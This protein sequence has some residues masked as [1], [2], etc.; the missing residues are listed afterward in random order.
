MRKPEQ[1]EEQT[2]TYAPNAVRIPSRFA[3][4][5]PPTATERLAPTL[6]RLATGLVLVVI[7]AAAFL[8]IP[9]RDWDQ[10][11]DWQ[12]ARGAL[13]RLETQPDSPADMKSLH[14]A[15][16]AIGI[17]WGEPAGARPTKLHQ[18][19][20]RRRYDAA[21]GIVQTLALGSIR[22]GSVPFGISALD[23][24]EQR[25]GA[26]PTPNLPAIP[27][28]QTT[29]DVCRTG[30]TEESCPS[31]NGQGKKTVTVT[32]G[33]SGFPLTASLKNT[34]PPNR[35]QFKRDAQRVQNCL[36]CQGT[37]RQT[38]PCPSCGG[39][40]NTVNLGA[41][42]GL[43]A[44]S[45][46]GTLA[47]IDE[48]MS[49]WRLI[50]TFANMQRA[51]L[52]GTSPSADSESDPEDPAASPTALRG[53]AKPFAY[54]QTA[55]ETLLTNPLSEPDTQTLA[56]VAKAETNPPTLRNLA[57]SAFGI[58]LLLR[59]NTSNYSR[60]CA[61]QKN[62]FGAPYPAPF[63]T[64]SDYIAACEDCLGKGEKPYPCPTCMG[65]NACSACEGK[66][67]IT[68]K[69]GTVPCGACKNKP[70]CTRCKGQKTVNASCAACRGEKKTIKPNDQIRAAYN[71][72]LADLIAY[73]TASTGDAP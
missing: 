27:Q 41:V 36:S 48:G 51:I 9:F 40:I 13:I 47:N 29:C 18:R 34:R 42:P 30:K 44:E 17:L 26:V 19:I 10:Y 62:T 28:L 21:Y 2:E 69:D 60:V 1:E 70:A 22:H 71:K 16:T 72:I 39:Q 67:R 38:K 5:K 25:T 49:L 73:C 15:A 46:R 56:D 33:S 43:L 14:S 11:A 35:S 31:C 3:K 6:K 32:N 58:S 64:E 37:G 8:L 61:I 54:V 4:P 23:R 68:T 12:A 7:A 59:G 53:E 20:Q 63:F 50:H 57:M 45:V 65:P 55:C 52:G 24:L 66:G